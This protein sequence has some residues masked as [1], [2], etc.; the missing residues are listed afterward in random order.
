MGK[1]SMPG[2]PAGGV[3]RLKYS[4]KVCDTKLRGCDISK[5]YDTNTNWPLLSEMKSCVGDAALA[6]LKNK[7]GPHTIFMFE[8]KY[9]KN[10]MPSWKTHAQWKEKEDTEMEEEQEDSSSGAPPLKKSRDGSIRNFFYWKNMWI[11]IRL[12]KARRRSTGTRM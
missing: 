9:T 1:T 2:T 3:S 7:A 12:L 4:C 11:P 6:E 5:H 10:S 8:H